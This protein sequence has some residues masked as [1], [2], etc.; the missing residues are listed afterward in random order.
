MP[1]TIKELAEDFARIF[2]G[3]ARSSGRYVVPDGAKAD[4]HGKVL[5]RPWTSREPITIE[6][7]EHHLSGKKATV[8]DEETLA[9]ITGSVGLGVVPIREDATVV[10]GAIDVDVYPLDLGKLGERVRE[11]GLPLIVCRTKSG[12][13]HLYLFLREPASAELVRERL[14]EWASALGHPGVEIFPKQALLS[15]HSDGSWINI[16]YSGGARSVRYAL[17]ADGTS[18]T[19]EEFVDAVAAAAV[20]PPDLDDFALP[21]DK[22]PGSEDFEGGPPCLLALARVGFGDWQNNGMF[23][24]AIYLKKRHGEGFESELSRYNEKYMSP[25]LGRVA[26]AAIA[27]SVKKK[28]YFYKCK[29]QPI[30]AVCNRS[31]CL[32]VPH[33]IGGGSGDSGVVIGELTKVLTEPVL[34]IVPVNGKEI[35]LTTGDLTDQRKFRHAAIERLSIWPNLVKPEEWQKSVRERLE[36]AKEVVA[37]EDGTREGQL[38]E[39][40]ANFCTARSRARN[41]DEVLLGKAFTDAKKGVAIFRS[42]DFFAYLA[43]HRFSIAERE[44]WRLLRRRGAEH[45][46]KNVKG[47]AV[48][49]WSV[50][51]FAEQT[52]EHAVPRA[53]AREEM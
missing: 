51:A 5:G 23:N 21:A 17:K 36:R 16:P 25:P 11:L 13:A 45:A 20:L 26:L 50:P 41:L 38:W 9:P 48:H 6:L 53:P 34:W 18:M 40:L 10:F 33:G 42:T 24:V 49:L 3:L 46:A 8:T 1:K 47:K 39:H 35:E 7:W 37:P 19:P 43:A 12:G 52:E 28:S 14:A 32:K 2:A 22:G 29:D 15:A 4:S 30:S 27:K 31:A 44:V